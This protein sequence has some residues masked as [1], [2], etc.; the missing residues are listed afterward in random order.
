MVFFARWIC[1]GVPGVVPVLTGPLQALLVIL[2]VLMRCFL[3]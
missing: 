3:N 2:P 1:C